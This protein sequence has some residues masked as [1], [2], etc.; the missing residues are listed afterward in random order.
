MS[1]VYVHV[2]KEWTL[3]ILHHITEKPL[4]VEE[5]SIDS[6]P[7]AVRALCTDERLSRG[8][9]ESGIKPLDVFEIL[10][11]RNALTR[12]SPGAVVKIDRKAQEA[13]KHC[14]LY[15]RI[16]RQ[17]FLFYGGSEMLRCIVDATTAFP[18][19]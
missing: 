10:D 9:P 4:T 19:G 12:C 14:I 6:W 16:F 1:D 5:E 3:T 2:P 18:G 8:E 11:L 17:P 13:L 7:K 15:N